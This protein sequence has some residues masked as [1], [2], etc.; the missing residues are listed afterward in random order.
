MIG[1]VSF[2]SNAWGG[3]TSDKYITKN[4]GFLDHILPGDLVL[5][6]RGF[7]IKE[8]LGTI[9][10]KLAIPV[11]TRGKKQLSP[12]DIES[13]RKIASVR[14]HVERVIGQVRKKYSILSGVMPVDFMKTKPSDQHC[15]LDK[16]AYVCCA[17]INLCP[18]VVNFE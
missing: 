16:I 14:I 10:S 18:S 12:L 15:M 5:A 2:I 7:D 11:F 9:H 1:S 8:T 17:L 4:S 13:T 3:R 6:D